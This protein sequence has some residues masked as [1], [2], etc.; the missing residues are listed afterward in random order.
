MSGIGPCLWHGSQ[1][2]PVIDGHFFHFYSIFVPAF[3]LDR[4]NFELN[5]F[6]E[7]WCPYPSTRSP[8]WLQEVA[9]S[10][11]MPPLLGIS[12]KDTCIDSFPIPRTLEH[13][14]IPA[15]PHLWQLQISIHSSGSLSCLFTHLILMTLPLFYPISPLP[16]L[17]MTI[18]F[19]LLR[20]I[21]APSFR[22]Y[23]L[24]NFFGSVGCMISILYFM[25]VT[26]Q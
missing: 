21:Q 7:G 4:T 10:G 16:L 11:C 13:P 26:Y 2:G 24:Y 6:W 19:P 14:K 12:A 8:A 1:V 23:S 15:K 20:E 9:S 18:L 22:P 5:F 25:V 3:L 17:P